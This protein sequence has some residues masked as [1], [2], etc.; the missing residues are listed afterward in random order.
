MMRKAYDVLQSILRHGG[1]WGALHEYALS[2]LQ[3][4]AMEIQKQWPLAQRVEVV[5]GSSDVR[6]HIDWGQHEG[7]DSWHFRAA[8]LAMR[9]KNMEVCDFMDWRGD[10]PLSLTVVFLDVGSLGHIVR[11]RPENWIRVAEDLGFRVQGVS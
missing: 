6:L 11:S 5:G 10:H 2:E 7:K 8:Y 3:R 4:S 9:P 1:T